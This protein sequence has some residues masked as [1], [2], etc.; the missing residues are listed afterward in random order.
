[1]ALPILNEVR[2]TKRYVRGVGAGEHDDSSDRGKYTAGD[3]C[4]QLDTFY[5]H[6]RESTDLFRSPDRV[7]AE[8][9]AG[10]GGHE[11][12]NQQ[13]YDKRDEGYRNGKQ[14]PAA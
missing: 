5:S 2:G 4:E 7:D 8:A 10:A 9:E 3:V 14:R 11:R 6:T 1:D 12:E 13:H